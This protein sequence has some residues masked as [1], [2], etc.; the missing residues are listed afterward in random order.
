MQFSTRTVLLIC[1]ECGL[2]LSEISPKKRCHLNGCIC[3]PK[4]SKPTFWFLLT[5]FLVLAILFV[6][7]S[8]ISLLFFSCIFHSFA[9]VLFCGNFTSNNDL[10]MVVLLNGYFSVWMNDF[11]LK[12]VLGKTFDE[13]QTNFLS[14]HQFLPAY[15]PVNSTDI[16][17]Q[18]VQTKVKKANSFFFF[19]SEL[20]RTVTIPSCV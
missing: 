16:W 6:Q 15:Y 14:V 17:L 2:A 8:M 3:C 7:A 18:A 11:L 13:V 9:A 4:T 10:W 1:T 20:L 12:C 5:A 19:C